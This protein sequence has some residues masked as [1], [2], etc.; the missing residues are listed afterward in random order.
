[1]SSPSARPEKE[2]QKAGAT[3][4]PRGVNDIADGYIICVISKIMSEIITF[5]S[6]NGKL[7]RNGG[8]KINEL[9]KPPPDWTEVPVFFHKDHFIM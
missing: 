6:E 8:R 2:V 1:M 5:G 3:A 4:L 7:F 9:P